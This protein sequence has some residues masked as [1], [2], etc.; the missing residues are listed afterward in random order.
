MNTNR[1]MPITQT[2]LEAESALTPQTRG[3]TPLAPTGANGRA[4]RR[5]R[6]VAALCSQRKIVLLM[7][8]SEGS[9]D[10]LGASN[11]TRLTPDD[12]GPE[13]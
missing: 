3:G 11:L 6:A 5:L 4:P 10:P 1:T 9:P 13:P 7:E 12:P 2:I 8:F